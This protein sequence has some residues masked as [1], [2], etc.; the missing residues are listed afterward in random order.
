VR[1][2]G[3]RQILRGAALRL[4]AVLWVF[5][6]VLV[7]AAAV[8][9][10]RSSL[11]QMF[12]ANLP[13]LALGIAQSVALGRLLDRLDA[14]PLVLRWP[15]MALAGVVAGIVQTLAD[16]SWLRI[17]SLTLVPE[18]QAWAAPWQP[19][20]LFLIF[21]LYAWTIFLNIA[22][23]WAARSADQARLNE[24]RA[25]A[26][27]AAALR[28]EAA[29]LR[30]QLN[31]HFLFNTLNGISSLVVRGRQAEAEEMIGRLA[32]FLR[33][34]LAADATALVPLRRELETISTYLDIEAARFGERLS[35]N[36][37]LPQ[38]LAPLKVPNFI[39]QPLVENAIKHGAARSRNATTITIS[40]RAEDGQAIISVV[41]RTCGA[42]GPDEGLEAAPADVRQGIGL[43]NTRQRLAVHYGEAAW[44]QRRALADG[45]RVEIGIPL[46]AALEPAA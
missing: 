3:V 39:L 46:E 34:S 35:T 18:W 10:G 33:A 5:G 44:L 12:L 28:A 24:A 22:L 6:Y 16:D 21:M 30:L 45:W 42:D 20:R 8:A 7:D 14:A 15:A 38:E 11:G 2:G 36:I 32:D 37:D 40:G 41:N 29:A 23:V 25:A 26:Y 4:S 1:L 31:P 13:L 19:Q 9:M 43:R 17:V 27:E